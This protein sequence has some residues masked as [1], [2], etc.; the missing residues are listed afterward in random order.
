MFSFIRDSIK[1]SFDTYDKYG[2]YRINALKGIYIFFILATFNM[3]YSVPNPYFYFFYLPLTALTSEMLGENKPA[4]YWLFF[5]ATMGGIV[6][7]F[8]F[9]L[10]IPYPI[11]F[12]FFVFFYSIIHYLIALHIVKNLLIPIPLALSL[13]SYSLVY[14]EISTDIY[15]DLNHI[16]ISFSA[17]LIIMAALLLF[18]SYYYFKAW[19]RAYLLLLKQILENLYCIQLNQPIQILVKGHITKAVKYSHMLSHRFPVFSVLK[20]NLLANDL[21]ILS[22]SIDQ[23]EIV[24]QPHTLNHLITHLQ[25][26]I[27]AVEKKTQCM[28]SNE[29]NV[30]LQKMIHSWNYL[31]SKI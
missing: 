13:A 6:A 1:S 22:S 14:G 4:K 31:C 8:L 24:I 10:F 3:I 16:L 11:F 15:I 2:E 20:T 21:R 28:V 25:L 19:H 17:M 23:K 7:V 27:E 9:N 12:E 30:T 26:F 29:K 18:P 5:H